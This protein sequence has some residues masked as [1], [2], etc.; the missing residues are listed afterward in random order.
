MPME[1]VLD[2]TVVDELLSLSDDGDPELLLDLI[3]LFLEDG[4]AKV[5]ALARGLANKD[6]EMMERA[7]HSLKGSAGNLG[8]RL[9]Q[10]TCERMMLASRQ[11]QLDETRQLAGRIAAAFAE[12]KSALHLLQKRYS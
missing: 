4:P 5:D 2:M 6:F 3:R 11:H 7:A 1:Q 12:A 9:L 8:A 10:H